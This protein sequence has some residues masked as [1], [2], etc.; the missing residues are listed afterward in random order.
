VLVA[1]DPERAMTIRS[2]YRT[3]LIARIGFSEVDRLENDNTIRRHTVEEL[4]EITKLYRAKFRELK[5]ARVA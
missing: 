2:A 1:H 4:Q 3:R 5:R